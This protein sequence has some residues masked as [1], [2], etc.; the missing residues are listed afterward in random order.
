MT[1]CPNCLKERGTSFQEQSILFYLSKMTCSIGR[2][3]EL[4]REI[5][6]FI[7]SLNT[8]IEYDGRFYHKNRRSRDSEKRKYLESKGIF[9]Q[10]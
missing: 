4:G 9:G 3:K 10:K 2:Y 1:G 6:V 8:G 5:D 7:P